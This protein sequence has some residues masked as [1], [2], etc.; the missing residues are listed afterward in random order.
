MKNEKK[1]RKAA[2]SERKRRGPAETTPL[3]TH[4]PRE[5]PPAHS[6]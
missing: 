3:T 2:R 6:T 4:Y 1:Q 5:Y